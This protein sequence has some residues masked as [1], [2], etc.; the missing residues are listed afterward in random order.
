[1]LMENM[2]CKIIFQNMPLSLSLEE[3]GERK[4]GKGRGGR[5]RSDKEEGME[6]PRREGERR[7]GEK[8]KHTGVQAYYLY[9]KKTT[10]LAS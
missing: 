5:E 10:S 2:A 3:K 1:M 6:G 7:G 8:R 9:R 4:R